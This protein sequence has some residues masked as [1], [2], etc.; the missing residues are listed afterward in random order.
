[1]GMKKVDEKEIE[2]NHNMFDTLH[3]CRS[4]ATMECWLNK[5]TM[6][7]NPYSLHSVGRKR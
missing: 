6:L 1:M 7:V 2:W 5:A 3:L 4:K